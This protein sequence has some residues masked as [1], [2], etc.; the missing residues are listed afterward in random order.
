MVKWLLYIKQML[1][2]HSW[3]WFGEYILEQSVSV[4]V[5]SELIEDGVV[6]GNCGDAG[7]GR[8]S[9][10]DCSADFKYI[11]DINFLTP[12]SYPQSETCVDIYTP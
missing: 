12:K 10:M 6:D 4:T 3:G 5:V 11:F 2:R 1:N 8:F 9:V 7:G